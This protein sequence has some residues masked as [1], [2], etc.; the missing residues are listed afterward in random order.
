MEKK[1]SK[2]VVQKND[3]STKPST[4]KSI[5]ANPGTDGHK[6]QEMCITEGC[7]NKA[8]LHPEWDNE[9]CSVNC[10]YNHCKTTFKTW[11]T[12]N[13]TAKLKANMTS[14]QQNIAGPS[15]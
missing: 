2:S 13:K 8:V 11:L 15:S 5:T 9:Y 10:C 14:S 6:T 12:I 1:N 7:K 3:A 4:S